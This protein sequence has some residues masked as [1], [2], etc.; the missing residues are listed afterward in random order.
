M[1][2]AK[3]LGFVALALLLGAAGFLLARTP[4]KTPAQQLPTAIVVCTVPA[5]WGTFRASS[6]GFLVFEDA[7][8][9]LRLVDCQSHSPIVAFE[10]RRQ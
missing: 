8:G 10:I 5:D 7:A 4:A 1:K 3:A 6:Q 2:I 9:T